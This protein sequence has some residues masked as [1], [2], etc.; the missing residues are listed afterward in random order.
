MDFDVIVIGSGAGGLAAAVPLAQAGK[1]VLVCEQHEVP[2]GWTHSFTLNGYRF[3]PG[4]HYIGGLAPGGSLR[5]TYE[6]LGV[7]GDLEFCEL[8]PD[9]YDHV[10]IG[11][12]QFDFPKGRENLIARLKDRFPHESAGIES[13]FDTLIGLMENLS[14]MGR[15]KAPGDALRAAGAAGSVVRWARRSGQDLIEAHVSDPV[16]KGILAAQAGDHGLPPSQVSAFIHAGITHHYLDG[17]YYPKGGAYVLPRAF[18]RALKRAGGQIQLQ[19]SVR[20][21]LLENGKATGVEL[22]D[23]TQISAKHIISNADPEVTLGKMVGRE[24]LSKRLR[25]KLDRVDYSTSSLSLFFATDMDLAAAGLDSGNYWFYDHAD[26]DA[27]YKLG[28]GDHA[29][30][31]DVPP[32]SFLTVTTLKDPSKMHTS[33]PTAGHHT[34]EMFSFV[35]Y[36]AFEKWSNS[37][38]GARPA[39]YNAMKEELSWKMFQ[40]LEGRVPGICDHIKFWSLATP[41]TNEHYINATRGNLYGISKSITQVGPGAFPVQTEIDGLLMVG[42]STLSHGVSGATATGIAAAR[43]ILNCRTEELFTQKGPALR[44]HESDVTTS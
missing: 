28:L 22:S 38:Y 6:G 24:H 14:Q 23:G 18:V 19:T 4:V 36:D 8:N 34:C 40:A 33:G 11:D 44:I 15:V 10:F 2:G 32:A 26:V 35:G 3:S 39:D 21:I 17:G 20:R 41:L 9:G 1:K 13:Y 27:L 7:S 25:R 30:R 29:L 5:R 12:E 42:A 37:R 43:K 16:L 31:A